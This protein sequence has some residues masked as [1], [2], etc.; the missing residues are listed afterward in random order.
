MTYAAYP[1]ENVHGLP[2]RQRFER[3]LE[4][5]GLREYDNGGSVREVV[6]GER[7]VLGLKDTSFA[8][9]D[10]V[11]I[12]WT[13]PGNRVKGYTWTRKKAAVEELTDADLAKPDI[14]FHWVNPEKSREVRV[15]VVHKVQGAQTTSEFVAGTFKVVAPILNRFKATTSSPRIEKA[16][17]LRAIRFG[18]LKGARGVTWDWKLTMP[19]KHGG[20]IKDLQTIREHRE[21]TRTKDGVTRIELRRHPTKKD[22]HDQLDQSL[23]DAGSEATYSAKDAFPKIELPTKVAAGKSFSDKVTSDSPHTA[24]EPEDEVMSVNDHFKYFILFKPDAPDA[25]WV[26]V[27]KAEWF[28]SARAVKR[29][30]EWKLESKAG[31]ISSPGDVTTEFPLYESNVNENK[32]LE[33]T[34]D[35]KEASVTAAKAGLRENEAGSLPRDPS[36]LDVK[37]AARLNRR[38][39]QS[40]GW[41]KSV[42]R[43]ARLLDL[44]GVTFPAAVAR[45]QT[46]QGMPAS[47]VID[48]ATWLRMQ[49]RIRSGSGMQSSRGPQREYDRPTVVGVA[50]TKGQLG[51]AFAQ[52]LALAKVPDEVILAVAG[53]ATFKEMARALED[54]Y[55]AL[56]EVKSS[57]TVDGG[58]IVKGD[59]TG[60][61][62]LLVALDPGFSQFTTL[63]AI[64]SDVDQDTIVLH[65]PPDASMAHWVAQI[66]LGTA[67]AHGWITRKKRTDNANINILADK[68][69][70]AQSLREADRIVYQ[71]FRSAGLKGEAK[72][73]LMAPIPPDILFEREMYPSARLHTVLEHLVLTE[74]ATEDIVKSKLGP[75]DI[76]KQKAVADA[77]PIGARPLDHYISDTIPLFLE[78][79][80]GLF[81]PLDSPYAEQRAVLRVIDAR[82]KE[83]PDLT[84]AAKVRERQEDHQV[85]FF[86]GKI[87][88]SKIK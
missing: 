46:S 30:G 44:R 84:A 59:R 79:V 31:K 20:S 8:G 55:V 61:R 18:D 22:A 13:V 40:L 72:P 6:I 47:G 45:W 38:M 19:A 21:R 60:K 52:P 28:W 68:K 71:A 17:T 37:E 25:I 39:A 34:K 49:A 76:R 78:P 88:Y 15:K 42:P 69:R 12:R 5:L 64:D 1:S 85:A 62:V 74:F 65:F 10:V 48:S 57:E 54:K 63:G 33:V 66:A 9:S 51:R 27:A 82:W 2:E 16:D 58:A 11:S 29:R 26:P 3:E 75:A 70:E 50:L 67:R 56:S 35:E 83:L 4:S 77:V 14:A 32:W 73:G 43:I 24:L 87:G 81:V 7:I 80:T 86:Q 23:W 41:K 53:S 36:R